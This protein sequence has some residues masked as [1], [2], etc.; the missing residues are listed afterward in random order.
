MNLFELETTLPM[1][2]PIARNSSTGSPD[3]LRRLSG[4]SWDFADSK[5]QRQSIHAIHPYPAKF[6][7]EIP[8]ALIAEFP[9]S[10]GSCVLDPF[11]GSGTSL[12]EAQRAGFDAV[13]VDLNPIACRISRVKTGAA[14]RLLG[15]AAA[16]CITIAEQDKCEA[17]Q[18]IPNLGHWFQADISETIS[19]LKTAIHAAA[20]ADCVLPLELALSSIIVRV[21]NQDSDTRYAAVAKNITRRQV[22]DLFLEAAGRIESALM[23]RPATDAMVQVIESDIL[24]LKAESLRQRV[25][26]VVTSPP[27]PNAYEY[28]LYHKYRMWW[29]GHDPLRVRKHEIG[30]RAHFFG[31]QAKAGDFQHQMAGVFRLLDSVCT[32]DATVCFVVGDSKIHGHIVDN[33]EGLKHAAE[34]SNFMEVGHIMRNMRASKKSFNLAHARIRQEH[35]LVFKRR[36]AMA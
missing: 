32:E 17:P 8:R 16:R 28:W 30:A 11:C 9:P 31:G 4:H 22:F 10:D 19:A 35:V 29:L 13:G 1:P 5:S 2:L 12:V 15:L 33:A 18:D 27:Y 36:N 23:R 20:P 25:G 24:A 3:V 21:S 34:A 14:P 7:P 26:L 6:I